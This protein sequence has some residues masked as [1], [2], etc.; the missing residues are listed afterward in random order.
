MLCVACGRASDPTPHHVTTPTA[1]GKPVRAPAPDWLGLNY[2][3]GAPTGDL[4]YF[5]RFGIVYDRLGNLAVNAGQT[6]GDT[7]SLA[8]GLRTSTA[9]GMIPDV[10]V[11]PA[12]GQTGCSSDPNGST[13]CLAD[14]DAD[15]NG[16]VRGF[17]S[18]VMSVRHAFPH[19]RVIFEPMNE[20]W[21]WAPPPGMT[22]GVRAAQL[23]AAVLARLY[24][25]LKRAG[26]PLSLIYVPATGELADLSYWIPDLYRT[27]PCLKPGPDTCGPIEGWNFHPYGPPNSTTS[28][29]GQIPSLRTAMPSGENNIVI[30]EMGFCATDVPDSLCDENTPT[31]DGSS[32]QAAR[33][34]SE[35]LQEGRAMHAAGW[36]RALIIW[37]RVGGG[38]AMQLHDAQ[39]TSQGRALIDAARTKTG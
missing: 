26:V 31:V 17:V 39:L 25:A 3:S 10:M 15:V 11:S 30:S 37:Q 5:S 35:A 29:I 4:T 16:F 18:T 8:R 13:L 1:V 38:W 32:A 21:N 22:S 20:P 7:P 28:G 2:N 24:P 19:R 23:Y 36:L 33:W 6:V 27:E 14:S 34:M 9:A 12:R